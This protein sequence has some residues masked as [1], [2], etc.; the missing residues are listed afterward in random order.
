MY[1]FVKN[2]YIFVKHTK[3]LCFLNIF[4]QTPKLDTV[5]E[6]SSH[7]VVD[8][9]L[10]T[11][12]ELEVFRLNPSIL[13][14]GDKRGNNAMD[15]ILTILDKVFRFFFIVCKFLISAR[16]IP[17]IYIIRFYGL[18]QLKKHCK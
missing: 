4:Y 16:S 3:N 12:L 9:L 18:A 2:L 13:Q 8:V 15:N 5:S 11:S 7:I 10:S 6:P 14:P 1:F 17:V